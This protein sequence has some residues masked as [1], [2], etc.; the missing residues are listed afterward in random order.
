MWPMMLARSRVH[1]D[2][3]PQLYLSNVPI[4]YICYRLM[5]AAKIVAIKVPATYDIHKL[6]T[7]MKKYRVHHYRLR[8]MHLIVCSHTDDNTILNTR[9]KIIRK[10]TR[11]LLPPP[12]F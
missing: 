1:L 4:E 9:C 8:K 11:T 2:K 5:D 10:V 12:G 3:K 6:R 7:V